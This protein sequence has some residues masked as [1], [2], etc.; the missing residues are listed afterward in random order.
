MPALNLHAAPK[1]FTATAALPLQIVLQTNPH[2]S[3]TRCCRPAE[4]CVFS[5]CLSALYVWGTTHLLMHCVCTVTA[6]SVL[7]VSPHVDQHENADDNA[8]CVHFACQTSNEAGAR[9]VTQQCAQSLQVVQF[10]KRPELTKEARLLKV[11]K[12]GLAYAAQKREELQ[13]AKDRQHE[14]TVVSHAKFSA[15]WCLQNADDVEALCEGPSGFSMQSALG[16]R[17][18]EGYD[19]LKWHHAQFAADNP[20]AVV[21]S[22]EHTKQFNQLK[23]TMDPS[24]CQL[25]EGGLAPDAMN[26]LRARLPA[27][28][29]KSTPSCKFC[30]N[31]GICCKKGM[32]KLMLS[33]EDLPPRKNGVPPSAPAHDAPHRQA[34][35]S[36]P[37]TGQCAKPRVPRSE[38]TLLVSDDSSNFIERR[39]HAT[40]AQ[41]VGSAPQQPVRA[42]HVG[43]K[44]QQPPQQQQLAPSRPVR[45]R[46]ANAQRGANF[47]AMMA[48]GTPL[49]S[50]MAEED[51]A[52]ALLQPQSHSQQRLQ[53]SQE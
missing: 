10:V 38:D 29:G 30:C 44:R 18:K 47:Y 53:M 20:D 31:T 14:A 43:R 24:K 48:A 3:W 52:C 6:L 1:S 13:A 36:V 9:T 23:A 12:E 50:D 37:V 22:S 11:G 19:A 2:G 21:F 46:R 49:D 26:A 39:P 32:L 16:Q 34:V 8:T 40:S 27:P 4:Q 51:G 33:Q 45:A 42:T 25:D 28:A 15:L 17:L 35:L 7:I 5:L 41:S